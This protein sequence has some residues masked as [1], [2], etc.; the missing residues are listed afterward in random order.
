MENKKNDTDEEMV[1]CI[2][3][4][5][6]ELFAELIHRYESKLCVIYTV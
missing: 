2:L 5:D 3:N 4:G 6:S 1:L